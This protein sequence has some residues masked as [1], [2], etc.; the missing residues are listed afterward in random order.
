LKDQGKVD[1]VKASYQENVT[2]K[3]VQAAAGK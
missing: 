2:A 1:A 3:F